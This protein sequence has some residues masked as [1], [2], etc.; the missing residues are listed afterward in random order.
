MR[1][2][3]AVCVDIYT[4]DNPDKIAEDIKRWLDKLREVG[5]HPPR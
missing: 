3:D 2:T 4:K 5:Q 1:P